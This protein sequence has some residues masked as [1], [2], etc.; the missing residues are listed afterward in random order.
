MAEQLHSPKDVEDRQRGSCWPFV[1]SK[2]LVRM[3]KRIMAKLSTLE[4]QLVD[5]KTAL[6]SGLAAINTAVADVQTKITA[7]TSQLADADIPDDAEATLSDLNA[8][9]PAVAAAATALEAAVNPQ[10]PTT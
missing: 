8:A 3:E 7:L 1:T 4:Q 10:A 9:V 2:D 5:L 6:T